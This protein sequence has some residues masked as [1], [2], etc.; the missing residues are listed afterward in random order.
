MSDLIQRDLSQELWREYEFQGR[1]YRIDQPQTLFYRAGGTTHRVVDANRVVH[2]LPAPGAF[3]CVL[4][5]QTALG[6]APVRF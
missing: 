4:R 5:W 6:N 3:G 2:C 1:V